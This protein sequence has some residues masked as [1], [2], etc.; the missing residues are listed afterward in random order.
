[1]LIRPGAGSRHRNLPTRLVGSVA[2]TCTRGLAPFDPSERSLRNALGASIELSSTIAERRR[3][4]AFLADYA[5]ARN[6]TT[7]HR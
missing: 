4:E 5:S 6:A 2:A 3:V 1:M 7:T